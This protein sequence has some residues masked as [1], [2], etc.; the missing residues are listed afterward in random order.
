VH[1]PLTVWWAGLRLG[2]ALLRHEP[3]LGLK[4]IVLPV[5]YWPAVE[6]SYVADRLMLPAGARALDVGS[7]KHL[8]I[9]LAQAYNLELATTDIR[10]KEIEQSI[11]YARALG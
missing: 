2:A 1:A 7:P 9:L 6:F 10:E 11:R 8:G 3:I 5:S 4:R